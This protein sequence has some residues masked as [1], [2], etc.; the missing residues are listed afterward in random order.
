MVT[1]E[2]PHLH[3][4]TASLSVR[5][6]SRHEAD[7][8]W[9]LSHLLEHMLFRGSKKFPSAR[10]LAEVFERSGGS[11][12]AST[13]R[14]HTNLSVTMHPSHLRAVLDALA[15]LVVS[16][17]FEGLEVERNIVEEELQGD[18][19]E[20]GQDTD[21]NNVSRASVWRGHPMGRRI[22]GSLESLRAFK[23]TDVRRHHANHY[24]GRNAVLC[25]AGRVDGLQVEDLASRVFAPLPAGRRVNDGEA[26]RFAPGSH[27]HVR[28]REGSQVAIQLT[29]EALPDV[30]PDF[31]A[32]NLLSNVLDDGMTSRLQ[33]ALCEQRGLVYELSTGLDCY[34]D[35]GLYDIE[36]KVAPRRAATAIAATFDALQGL[37]VGGVT[38]AELEMARE[39]SLHALEFRID[40][41]EE[42]AQE[43]AASTLFTGTRPLQEE[44]ARLQSVTA[45]DLDRV[46]KKLFQSG[47]VHATLLGP[48]ERANMRRIEK[49]LDA[50]ACVKDLRL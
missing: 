41:P 10:A 46:A 5:C 20:A 4:A 19:D 8:Q 31:P 17:R 45:Q 14:D 1:V 25:V 3:S 2:Q 34:A 12:Q 7:T 15:D 36:M 26:A 28:P 30:H 27:L 43:Y 37:C 9:G 24:V 32:L 23:L 29:F 35:C 13:W 39:R 40:S 21:L 38:A 48:V 42:L 11:L 44:A 47:R 16:P 49:L 18:L 50:F 6:G 22:T 33:H